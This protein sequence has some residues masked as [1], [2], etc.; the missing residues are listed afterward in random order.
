MENTTNI[1]FNEL[2][3]I[4][5]QIPE[6]RVVSLKLELGVDKYPTLTLGLFVDGTGGIDTVTKTFSILENE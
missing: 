5:P 3:K 6:N 4:I 2:R 1:I